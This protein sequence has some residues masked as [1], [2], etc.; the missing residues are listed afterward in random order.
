MGTRNL[1]MVIDRQGTIKVAQYGQW[2]GYPSGNGVEI[3]AFAKDKNNLEKLEKRLE[4]VEFVT[5]NCCVKS[6]IEGYNKRAEEN[7]RTENDK[8]FYERFISRDVGA[9]I[10]KNIIT[11][12]YVDMPN[13]LKGTIWLE[14]ETDFGKDSIFCEWAY[15]INFQTNKLE[16][17]DGFNK[18]KKNQHPRFA[19]KKPQEGSTGYYYGIR[20]LKEYDLDNLPDK[21]DF[22]EDLDT[23]GSIDSSPDYEED[24]EIQGMKYKTKE[25]VPVSFDKETPVAPIPTQYGYR[26]GRHNCPRCKNQLPSK[27]NALKKKAPR[28]YCDRCGQRIDWESVKD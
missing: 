18:S 3:L 16:C 23:L 15:C 12:D 13:E 17:F 11:E 25:V 28:L 7:C 10:L 9:D 27:E 6:F 21:D 19:I 8:Y 20:L 24:D 1:T 14:D 26:S 4:E 2:D 5:P 22:I